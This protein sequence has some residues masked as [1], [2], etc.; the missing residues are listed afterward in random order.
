MHLHLLLRGIHLGVVFL[1]EAQ[2]R[3]LAGA[4]WPHEHD[5]MSHVHHFVDLHGLVEPV[6]F[7]QQRLRFAEALEFLA[8]NGVLRVQ[9]GQVR[10][11]EG[12]A[13]DL[14]EGLLVD[15]HELGHHGVADGANH[16][17]RLDGLHGIWRHLLEARGA[18][19]LELP[20]ADE[21][22][23]ESAQSEVVVAL[24][25]ELLR[26]E[27]EEVNHL[28][29]DGLGVLQA[30]SEEHDLRDELAVRAHHGHGAEEKLQVVREV[31][32]AGVIRIHGYEDAHARAQ[33]DAL[34]QEGDGARLLL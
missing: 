30:L 20:G 15:L 26:A 32:A 14:L 3:R 1:E 27:L 8:H 6:R 22:A 7:R 34:A 13:Q 18:E 10:V 11:G 25:G 16:G 21:N 19:A 29:A 12:G 33:S 9:L 24:L 5:A 28:L 2:R 23:L 17:H 4:R 31:G